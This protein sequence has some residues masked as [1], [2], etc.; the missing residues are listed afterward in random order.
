M[1]IYF[2]YKYLSIYLAVIHPNYSQYKQ[3]NMDGG[4]NVSFLKSPVSSSLPAVCVQTTT[5][6]FSHTSF[7]IKHMIMICLRT[8]GTD[9]KN[10][11]SVYVNID[12]LQ[13]G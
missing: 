10:Q 13:R 9:Y 4:E 1:F 5:W 6:A 3:T 11:I 8:K 12:L 7:L 2:I